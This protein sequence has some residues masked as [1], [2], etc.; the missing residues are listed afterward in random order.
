MTQ[1]DVDLA[2]EILTAAENAVREAASIVRLAHDG[3]DPR[4]IKASNEYYD[5]MVKRALFARTAAR[6]A[7]LL[8]TAKILAR[9]TDGTITPEGRARGV[10][11]VEEVAINRGEYPR[12]GRVPPEI[13]PT[14][15]YVS[16][17]FAQAQRLDAAGDRVSAER[18]VIRALTILMLDIDPVFREPERDRLP[19][20][21]AALADSEIAFLAQIGVTDYVR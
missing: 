12:N 19:V 16:A 6:L 9:L 17:L 20:L 7:Q 13:I 4:D 1:K 15:H 8:A 10:R 21:S 3:G 2:F 18:V 5:A 14:R 11:A